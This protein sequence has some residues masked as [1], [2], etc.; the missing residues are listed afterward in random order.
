LP[1]DDIVF[2]CFNGL[3]KINKFTFDRWLEIL[4]RVPASVLWLLDGSEGTNRRLADYAAQSGVA[5]TRVIF[6]PR[7]QNAYH[8]ARYP[9]AD[10]FLDTAPY[11]AHTTASDALWM[12]VPVLTLSGRS[13]ASRV[14]G[15]LVRSAGLPDLVCTSARD[16]VERAVALGRDRAAIAAYKAKLEEGRRSCT[17]FATDKLARGLEALYRAMCA[18]YRQGRLPRPDLTNLERYLE[19]GFS[20]DHE[21]EE[22]LTID[23]YHGLYKSRLAACHE[24]QPLLPDDRIWSAKDI[25]LAEHAKIEPASSSEQPAPRR[26]RLVAG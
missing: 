25:E 20:L 21:A 6:A 22:L 4:R 10:L 9:L 17:L 11:G 7:Q 2:C 23:D 19:A 13:F 3:H 24:A 15:S 26:I 14:C 8:L 16:Y 5:R 12:G 18:D 1:D